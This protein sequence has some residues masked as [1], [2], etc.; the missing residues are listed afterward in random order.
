MRKLAF[1]FTLTGLLFFLAACSIQPPSP[2]PTAIAL[3]ATATPRPRPTRV[4]AAATRA[5]PTSMPATVTPLP[6]EPAEQSQLDSLL[7]ERTVQGFVM[8]LVRGEAGSAFDL[9]LTDAARQG[10]AGRLLSRFTAPAPRVAEATLLGL[11]QTAPASREA[12]VV[13][14]WTG[15]DD[16]APATE[17]MTLALIRERGLWLIDAIAMGDLQALPT[18]TPKAGSAPRPRAPELTGKLVFQVSSGGDVD[19]INADGSGLYRLTDGLDPAWSP[20]GTRI[21]FTRW[22]APWG[23]YLIQPDGRGETRV[24]DGIRLKE[25]AW[26]PDASQ[27]AV[28]I[29][30]SSSEPIQIC[31]FGFCFTL[32]PFSL[33]QMWVVNLDDGKALSVPLD[34][35]VVHSPTWTPQGNRILYAGQQGLAWI[36]LDTMEKGRF[37]G[38]SVW[39]GSPSVSPDGRRIA[40]MGRVHNRWEIW[41]M[42]ADG[43]GRG[44]LTRSAPELQD[45]PNNV[46]PAWS[47]D[48]KY[49]AFLSDRDGPWRVYL[50]D[51]DGSGQ[52]P[53]FGDKLDKLGMRYEFASERVLSWTR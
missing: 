45:P 43:S 52:R 9:Y 33:G 20:D 7:A 23:T 30:V 27:I 1:I 26:S 35:R 42:N 47:P 25:V 46:A 16:S 34:D 38:G 10:D 22:R 36:D 4:L 8:H 3:V 12:Q 24:A 11:K 15:G 48:G 40:Y 31:F 17:A 49:I 28:T 53:M 32:P 51:A 13:L 50:M 14:Q 37:D 29:N 6:P 39:D 2:T 41:S 19:V 21:A 18:A 5:E 44:Q